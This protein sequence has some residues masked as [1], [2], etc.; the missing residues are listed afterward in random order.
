LTELSKRI[1]AARPISLH[2]L[3]LRATIAKYWQELGDQG[4]KW[5][6][7]EQCTDWE[8]EVFAHLIDGVLRFDTPP[9]RPSFEPVAVP[10]PEL[11]TFRS[12][13]AGAAEFRRA[14]PE[15]EVA[16][17][18]YDAWYEQNSKR[19]DGVWKLAESILAGKAPPL[20]VLSAIAVHYI[21]DD[22]P[23]LI[24]RAADGEAHDSLATWIVARLLHAVQP[25][26]QHKA[27]E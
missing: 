14:N 25:S 24:A 23:D 16:G 20:D 7:P 1:F 15:P 13:L 18:G 11:A 19:V 17:P 5:T 21:L 2:N 6:L 22:H 12:A 3:K 26:I 10:S 9:D 4:E 8:S 27:G